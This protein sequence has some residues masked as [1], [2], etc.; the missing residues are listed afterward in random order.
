MGATKYSIVDAQST[1]GSQTGV[2]QAL[3]NVILTT[4]VRED[5]EIQ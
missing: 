3:H 5:V 2:L 1:A 4:N